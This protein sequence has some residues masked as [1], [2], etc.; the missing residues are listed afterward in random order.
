MAEQGSNVIRVEKLVKRYGSVTAVDGLSFEVGPGEIFGMLG[1]NGAGKT[2]TIEAL[3][4]LRTPDAG[5]VEVLGLHPIRDRYA[6]RERIG[7]QLQTSALPDRMKVWEA[8]DLFSSLYSHSVAW[9]PL[10][11]QMGLSDKRDA[12]YGQLSGGL[13][14]RLFIALALVNEPAL[15][16]LDELSAGLDPQ[17]RRALWELVAGVRTRG[18]SVVLA[19]HYMDEAE[20]LCDRIAI[21]DHGRMVALDPPRRL[22]ASLGVERRLAFD[23]E[24]PFDDATLRS[25]PGVV[26]VERSGTRVIVHGK[27]EGIARSVMAALE[28][29]HTP[30]NDLNIS[31]PT[32]EDVFLS[33]TGSELRS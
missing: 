1:P 19:T 21:I 18:A 25:L 26:R 24:A 20:Q 12:A 15:V 29:A 16:F 9:E 33:L 8:L 2:T 23:V 11:E 32:L 30:F 10:L 14:Q 28:T 4:G 27:D 7:V 31:L 22:I 17:A 3:I 6:L 13:K 5:A